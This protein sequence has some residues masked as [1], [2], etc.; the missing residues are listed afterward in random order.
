MSPSIG[1]AR[2]GVVSQSV[3]GMGAE[4]AAGCRRRRSSPTEGNRSQE[5]KSV[6][7]RGLK[8]IRYLTEY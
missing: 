7:P 2:R 5:I 1:D 3:H 6:Y 8:L 4:R